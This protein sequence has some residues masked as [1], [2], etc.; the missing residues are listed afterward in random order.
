M[1]G[2]L[3]AQSLSCVWLFATP[4]AVARQ[5]PLS[6]GFSRQEYWSGQPS[7]TAG[8]LPDPGIEPTSLAIPSMTDRFFT[9]SGK[10]MWL[11]C[12]FF[13]L[14]GQSVFPGQTCKMQVCI[15]FKMQRL[16]WGHDLLISALELKPRRD[17]SLVIASPGHHSPDAT[18]S[19]TLQI[20]FFFSPRGWPFIFLKKPD[21][22]IFFLVHHFP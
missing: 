5:A 1:T 20:F 14:I 4:W 6:M 16:K 21:Y 13:F 15:L 3:C 7:P 18:P 17:V 12:Y 2:A 9:T 19:W 11:T 10:S 22:L 8:D